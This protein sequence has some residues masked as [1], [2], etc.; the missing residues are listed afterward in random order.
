M[1]LYFDVQG[2][3]VDRTTAVTTTPTTT[4]PPTTTRKTTSTTETQTSTRGSLIRRLSMTSSSSY[5]N[6]V[7]QDLEREN[8]TCTYCI[9]LHRRE[10]PRHMYYYWRWSLFWLKNPCS[11][12][13]HIHWTCI[14]NVP[15][16][17]PS[18][19]TSW[20]SFHCLLW[21]ANNQHATLHDSKMLITFVLHLYIVSRPQIAGKFA[22]CWIIFAS[23]TE[24]PT[25]HTYN[26]SAIIDSQLL[27]ISTQKWS[28]AKP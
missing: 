7:T 18:S 5:D 10:K 25:A 20:C 23:P 17:F 24:Q 2:Y 27:R 14:R 12:F 9:Y 22:T 28:G 26:F 13:L 19:W 3:A 4:R 11:V 6:I 15:F 1:I 16:H 21:S 8:L